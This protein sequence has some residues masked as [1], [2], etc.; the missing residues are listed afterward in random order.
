RPPGR[1]V[2]E[3]GLLYDARQRSEARRLRELVG[4]LGELDAQRGEVVLL[5]GHR[6]PEYDRGA[7]G[8]EPALG[9]AEVVEGLA[10]AGDAPLL[11]L[12]HRVADARRN[13]KLPRDGVPGGLA[14]R[15]ADVRV[16]F[17]R[18]A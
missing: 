9:M 13:R 4:E 14:A 18:S 12:V 6:V 5:A 2:A 8:I 1:P 17:S 11:T 10:R 15:A 3:D 7:F 16:G